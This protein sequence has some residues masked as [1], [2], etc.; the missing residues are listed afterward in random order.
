MKVLSLFANVGFGEYLFKEH[1][2]DVVVANELLEDDT[3]SPTRP[4]N[5]RLTDP[6][7]ITLLLN[8]TA[9]I[10]SVGVAGYRLDV[11]YNSSF[12]SLVAG[13]NNKDVGNVT[14]FLITG[15]TPTTTYY[16][17]LRAY[18]ASGNTS[19]NSTY[20]VNT[21]ASSQ[22]DLGDVDCNGTAAESTDIQI[23]VNV[24][25]GVETDPGRIERADLNGDKRNIHINN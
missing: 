8:W 19:Y 15:L 6:K 10:D 7:A 5:L 1:G 22:C 23:V 20:S 2:F 24:R 9:S 4:T 18:D 16:A 11:S 14:Q 12:S 3:Q 21:T 25:L 13:Y 17:R